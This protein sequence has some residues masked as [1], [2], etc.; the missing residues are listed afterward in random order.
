MKEIWKELYD[1]PGYCV[2]S[3]GRVKGPRSILKPLIDKYGYYRIC[4]YRNRKKYYKFIHSL[5][6]ESFIGP[7]PKGYECNHKDGKKENNKLNNL[8]WTTPSENQKHAF[9]LGLQTS[10]KGEKCPTRKL[11][12][13]DVKWIRDIF[14]NSEY[15]L[16]KDGRK[17]YKNIT[18]KQIANLFGICYQNIDC[19][20]NNKTWKDQ[21]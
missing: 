16:S 6:L 9:R 3:L 2:S 11:S 20:L 17:F 5:I 8:E 21:E 18:Y 12:S 1:F 14:N 19:I 7:R 4:L 15:K 13:N 10:L